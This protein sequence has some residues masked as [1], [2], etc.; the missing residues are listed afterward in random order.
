[1]G[2]Q[3]LK[4]EAQEVT[5][6]NTILTQSNT[7]LTPYY[8]P[9]ILN[10]QLGIAPSLSLFS[11]ADEEVVEAL[12]RFVSAKQK[13]R[14]ASRKEREMAWKALERRELISQRLEQM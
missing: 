14:S 13:K 8:D 4:K 2:R 1:M 10:I 12:K 7:V 5:Q 6:T 3:E 11:Q 9:Y